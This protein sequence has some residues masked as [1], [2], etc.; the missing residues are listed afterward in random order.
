[1]LVVYVTFGGAASWA[2]RLAGTTG[3]GMPDLFAH[4][5][6]PI[7]V[8]YVVAHYFTLFVLEGQRTLVLLS[9]PLGSGADWLGI[10]DLTEN[11]WIADQPTL[12]ASIQVGAIVLGHVLG[13]VSAHDRA[14]RLFPRRSAVVAQL[15]LLGVMV[16]YTVAGL[17]LLFAA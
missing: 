6:V 1:M 15:P 12:V 8:G 2:G 17:L 3:R 16:G 11:R 13:I 5:V 7:A 10:G 4:S 14:V 9:D